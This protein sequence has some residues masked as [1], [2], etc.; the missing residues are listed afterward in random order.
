MES[1]L[2][3]A[4]ATV[5]PPASTGTRGSTGHRGRTGAE[6]PPHSA[7]DSRRCFS[8]TGLGSAGGSAP[9][10]LSS[11]SLPPFC[12]CHE[13]VCAQPSGTHCL[14]YPE[15]NRGAPR[16]CSESPEPG[17]QPASTTASQWPDL[18]APMG[19][20]GSL[21]TDCT[22]SGGWAV[23]AEGRPDTACALAVCMSQGT[24]R[25]RATFPNPSP[26]NLL[27]SEAPKPSS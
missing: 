6:A 3:Q 26:A 13:D 24:R 5:G 14:T 8:R 17:P 15:S 12:P 20:A 23:R 2:G 1:S 25:R 7:S 22:A 19:P 9:R 27:H 4:S 16:G 18:T 11:L 10:Q 21:G